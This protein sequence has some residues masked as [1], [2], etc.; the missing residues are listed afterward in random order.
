[1]EIK[2][3]IEDTYLS[4]FLTLI[5]KLKYVKVEEIKAATHSKVAVTPVTELNDFQKFL[6]TG[7][8]MSDEDYQFFLE[9]RQ[10]FNTWK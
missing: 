8:V 3:K 1:M 2:L 4:T 10:D 5:S 9:K 6:L 7:P